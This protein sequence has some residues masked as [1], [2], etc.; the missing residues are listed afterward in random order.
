MSA[1]KHNSELWHLKYSATCQSQCHCHLPKHFDYVQMRHH[2]RND[3]KTSKLSHAS[4]AK[5]L[6]NETHQWMQPETDVSVKTR[7]AVMHR[8]KCHNTYITTTGRT[9]LQ[10]NRKL[11]TCNYTTT[12]L[13][14]L[15]NL[16]CAS[17]LPSVLWH[18][19]LGDRKSIQPV[20]NWVVGCWRG[21]LS[22]ARCR[23]EY[24]PAD[25][26]ATHCLLLQ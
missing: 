10:Q 26:T 12:T 14:P 17:C 6:Y 23:L 8:A 24:G 7:S 19:W 15:Y 9:S 2:P 25:A 5:T 1:T 21:C 13:Q 3:C 22:G 11:M 16:T 4:L 18:C 20:K